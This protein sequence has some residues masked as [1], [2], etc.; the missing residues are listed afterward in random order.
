MRDKYI[1]ILSAYLRIIIGGHVEEVLD[2]LVD[3]RHQR[4]ESANHI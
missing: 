3:V 4:L 2:K 1:Y